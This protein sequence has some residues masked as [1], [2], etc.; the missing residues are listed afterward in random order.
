MQWASQEGELYKGAV[1]GPGR[2]QLHFAQVQVLHPPLY[3]YNAHARPLL[4][5]G[6]ESWQG[7]PD[8]LPPQAVLGI[9]IL[10][11]T[12]WDSGYS[13]ILYQ[14]LQVRTDAP[15]LHWPA[16]VFNSVHF[17]LRYGQPDSKVLLI[18]LLLPAR[19][20]L[21][22][23]QVPAIEHI[24]L[25]G[26]NREQAPLALRPELQLRLHVQTENTGVSGYRPFRILPLYKKDYT[27][28]EEISVDLQA[29]K[30]VHHGPVR[31]LLPQPN[32]LEE[33]CL[34]GPQQGLLQAPLLRPHHNH[35]N[36]LRS[37]GQ[38]T[39][40]RFRVLLHGSVR[41]PHA[42]SLPDEHPAN[43]HAHLHPVQG[44]EEPEGVSS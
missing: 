27:I 38:A 35:R 19:G 37:H 1:S 13:D 24:H 22:S 6:L 36:N 3:L 9:H 26:C 5:H 44:R 40:W 41:L 34:E 33:N 31:V 17:H 39:V 29:T 10:F 11:V 32:T 18:F 20:V 23:G 42:D 25:L 14:Q 2:A 30:Q 16:F 21:H 7:I 8:Y 28:Q 43:I 4:H 15:L 12:V